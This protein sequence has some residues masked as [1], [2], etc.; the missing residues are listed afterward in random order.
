MYPILLKAGPVVLYSY[1]FFVALGFLASSFF[2][3]RFAREEE[4]EEEKLLDGILVAVF[5]GLAGAR[6]YYVFLNWP[7]FSKDVF[8]IF[9][10]I[11]YPGL[12]IMGGLIFGL[13]GFFLF[14]RL[15]KLDFAKTVDLGAIGL[16]L[17]QAIGRIG[18]FLNGC[19]YGKATSAFWGVAFPGLANRRHPT[20]LYEAVLSFFIFLVLVSVRKNWTY[21]TGRPFRE[22]RRGAIALLYF[23]LYGGARLMVEFFRDD[24]VYYAGIDL[25][26]LISLIFILGSLVLLV[27]F[28]RKDLAY[29]GRKAAKDLKEVDFC[30]L[31][32]RKLDSNFAWVRKIFIKKK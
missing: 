22:G 9:H 14:S 24:I 13:A 10:L 32:K 20:Q 5:S 31:L 12:G 16:S 18:C 21:I 8:R 2:V 4:I 30:E 1:G 29:F 26:L 3:W 23:F 28:F 17:G 15:T 11:A 27:G 6:L 7:V 19:C 25:V